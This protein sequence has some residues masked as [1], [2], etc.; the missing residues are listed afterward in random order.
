[1]AKNNTKDGLLTA[2][3][4]ATYGIPPKAAC[5][6][7]TGEKPCDFDETKGQPDETKHA[8]PDR[9]QPPRSEGED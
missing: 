4:L 9:G 7:D 1:M 2:A 8:R 3:D 6:T 5:G